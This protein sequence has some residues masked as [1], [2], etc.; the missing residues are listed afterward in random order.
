MVK[1]QN[2]VFRKTG[3]VAR[4]AGIVVQYSAMAGF[5]FLGVNSL[6]RFYS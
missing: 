5:L 1:A 6:I 2:M 4:M 3:A